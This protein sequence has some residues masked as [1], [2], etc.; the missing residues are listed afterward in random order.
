MGVVRERDERRQVHSA[1]ERRYRQDLNAHINEL[2]LIVSA[3]SS[4]KVKAAAL[5]KVTILKRTTE[6]IALMQ[7]Q[8][9][10]LR[11]AQKQHDLNLRPIGTSIALQIT[12]LKEQQQ[13]IEEQQ[14]VIDFLKKEITAYKIENPDAFE[15]HPPFPPS[16]SLLVSCRTLI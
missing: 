7:Q 11:L 13:L 9:H 5:N 2:K 14:A 3:C 8:E 12:Q 4:P 6:Y 1:T 16:F 15:V 10:I